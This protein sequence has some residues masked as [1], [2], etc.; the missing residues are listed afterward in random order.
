MT[1]NQFHHFRKE[2]CFLGIFLGAALAASPALGFLPADRWTT[3]AFGPA[4]HRGRPVT[5]TWSVVPDGTEV[6]NRQPSGLISFLDSHFQ[7]VD[8]GGDDDLTRRPWFALIESAFDRWS[9][10]GGVNFVYEPNDDGAIHGQMPGEL[11]VRGDIR[12]GGTS[13]DGPG[14]TLAF[15]QFPDG[16]DIG[17]DTDDAVVLLDRAAN[18]RRLRNVL[19]HE[20]GHTLGLDHVISSDAAFLMEP[21]AEFSYDGPQLDDIRGLHHLYGDRLETSNHGTGNHSASLATELG[22]MSVGTTISL[23]RDAGLDTRVNSTDA[24]FLSISGS[25]DADFFAFE[26]AEPALLDVKLTPL[27]GL[28]H[29]GLPG[30]IELLTNAFASSDLGFVVLAA[31][32]TPLAAINQELAGGVESTSNLYLPAAGRYFVQVTGGREVV[33]LYELDLT[34]ERCE[35]AEPSTLI[36]AMTMAT[37]CG[38]GFC[39]RR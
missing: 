13:D 22:L 9:K 21:A 5:L 8:G 11:G 31:D 36:A 10:L 26:V 30:G 38:C 7:V 37:V 16:A 6:R 29:Q 4:D 28:F 1:S 2:R 18:Y 12:L 35:I 14:G 17:L 15:S 23:G 20:V 25:L 27:G 19:M 3:T 32:S 33:Q 24:D 39:R 34:L